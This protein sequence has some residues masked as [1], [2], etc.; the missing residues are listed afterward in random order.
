MLALLLVVLLVLWFLGYGP[1]EAFSVPL[2][3]LNARTVSIWDILIFMIILSIIGALPSPFRE[4]GV[5]FLILW[6]FAVL[7]ILAFSGLSSLVLIAIIGGLALYLLGG[8]LI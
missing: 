3:Q 7:G 8:A 4:I 2:F 5:V 6:V 1:I